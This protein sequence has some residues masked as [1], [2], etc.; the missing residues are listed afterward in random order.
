M[1][2]PPVL[3]FWRFKNGHIKG[4]ASFRDKRKFAKLWRNCLM[5][6]YEK[7]IRKICN[8]DDIDVLQCISTEYQILVIKCIINSNQECNQFSNLV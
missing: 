7:K 3:Y 5:H 1:Q 2:W 6:L 8:L 4:R